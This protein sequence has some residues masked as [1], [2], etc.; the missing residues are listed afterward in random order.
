[1]VFEND[2]HISNRGLPVPYALAYAGACGIASPRVS[3]W[4]PLRPRSFFR[5]LIGSLQTELAE[6]LKMYSLNFA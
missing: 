1:M 2:N 3:T 5:A 6:V 4:W